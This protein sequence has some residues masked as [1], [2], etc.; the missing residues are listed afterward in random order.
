MYN[1][2]NISFQVSTLSMW[3]VI[4]PGMCP[5]QKS[6][7]FHCGEAPVIAADRVYTEKTIDG[8]LDSIP[9]LPFNKI[10]TNLNYLRLNDSFDVNLEIDG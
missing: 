9:S 8:Y 5:V 4:Q 6:G 2:F 1:L 10:Q 7:Q 3:L